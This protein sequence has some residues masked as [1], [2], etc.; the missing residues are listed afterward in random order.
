MENKF[1]SRSKRPWLYFVFNWNTPV[2]VS[3][4]LFGCVEYARRMAASWQ[5]PVPEGAIRCVGYRPGGDPGR[6]FDDIDLT[7]LVMKCISN[8]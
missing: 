3:D 7:E 4:T 6:D 5:P 2:Y 1:E 8:G